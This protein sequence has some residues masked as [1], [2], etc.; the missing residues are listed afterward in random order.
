MTRN[1]K[2]T[3]KVKPKKEQ[4]AQSRIIA[5]GASAGGL[6]ALKAYFAGIP[7]EDNN[8]YVV[9]QHLSPDYKSM[10]GELLAKSTKFPIKQI[11]DGMEMEKRTIYLIPPKCNLLAEDG[12]LKLIEK[13]ERAHLNLPID[14]FLESLSDNQKEQAIAVILSG[15]GSDGSRGI[16]AIKDKDGMVMVQDPEQAK[17]D[18]MPKSAIQT[19]LVD[20]ILPVEEMGEELRKFINAPMVFD[21]ENHDVE[22]NQK[23]LSKILHLIDEKTGLDFREYKYSTL[24]RR[25]ARRVNVS[26]CSNLEEYY[27]MLLHNNEEI[28]MLYR[29]FLIGVTN[30][31]RD[32]R[33]WEIITDDIIPELI[34]SKKDN[35]ILKIWDVGCSTGEEAYS[36]AM[37]LHEEMQRQDKTLEVKIFATDISQEHLDFGSL[38]LYSESIVGNVEE[39]F[40][41][42]FFVKKPEGYQVIEK[43]RR[44]VIFS[45]HNIIKNPPFSNMDAVFCRNLLIYFQSSIQKKAMDVLHYSLKEYGFL[46]LGTSESVTSHREYFEDISRKWKIFR[47]ISPRSRIR[48]QSLKSHNTRQRFDGEDRPRVPKNRETRSYNVSKQ[49]YVNELNEAIMQQFGAA[50][51]YVD[52]EFN[53]MEAVGEFRKYANLPVSGFS[54]NLIEMLHKDLKHVVQSTTKKAAK[55]NNRVVYYDAIVKDADSKVKKMNIVVKPF[56]PNNIDNE[57]NFVITFIEKEVHEED[58][59]EVEQITINGRTQEYIVELEE[60]LRKTKEE[61]QTSLEEIETSNEELQAANEELLASNEELQSTNEELQSV[62]EEINTVNA[63]NIQKMDDLAQLNADMNNLL[64]STNIGTIFLDSELRI[65]KFTP[66]IKKHFSLINSDIGRPIDNFTTNFGV[67]RGKGLVDRCNK[68][69][70]TG[71]I[72]ERNILSKEGKNYLQRIS[73]F[74]NGED[75]TEGI[76]ITF[77]DIE[78]LQKAKNKLLASERRFK[79]FYEEDPVLHFSVDPKTSEIVQCNQEAVDK[80]GYDSKEDIIGKPIFELYE[81]ESKLKALRLNKL[82]Q[83]KGELKNVEQEMITKNGKIVPVIM[84]STVELDEN[85]NGITNRFTCVDI[86]ELKHA[87]QELQQQKKDLERANHDL[88]QFVSICSH[89]LQEPLSTIKFGSDILGKIYSDKLDQKGKDYIQYIDEASDRLSAQIKAL[90]EHSRIGRNTKKKM[91]DTRELV[92]VVKYDLTKRIKDTNAKVHVGTLPKLKVYEIEMRLL[93]Q[94]L[95]SN[96]LKYCA[97]DKTPEVR[98]SAYQEDE[99]W[100]FSVMDNGIG[101]SEEDQKNIFTIFNRVPTEEKYEGT[102]VGLAHVHKIVILHGGSIW[103][104]SQPGVGSTFYFK[105]KAK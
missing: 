50:S 72:L 20:Y 15:T 36:L 92:E 87:Q 33:V 77:V 102:G 27:D 83:E 69:M 21:I 22:F 54:T 100:V 84:N 86:S 94:N 26:G 80:L 51:V 61:L 68:V 104:D 1:N 7:E 14:M 37:L 97:K 47:N 66:A 11:K 65:R 70:E 28:P 101:I 57:N 95:L 103:V 2:L 10:M 6:E 85:G 24:G 5:V 105:I 56:K 43:I 53:I 58:T 71:K 29:E 35:D 78:S 32:Q 30:F 18:G 46:I 96:A 59:I 31:F 17:F 79:S 19:G 82:F 44:M 60:E 67:N 40:L 93:F 41:K 16:R 88:E 75:N 63:E 34:E 48:T 62:N 39:K 89:D 49:K 12:H 23:T 98:I 3:P 52:S 74:R 42:K 73:P 45:R 38:G 9:I 76:V 64:E 91:V 99:Y 55:E 90:L 4:N 81:D 13:P 25:I 8:I